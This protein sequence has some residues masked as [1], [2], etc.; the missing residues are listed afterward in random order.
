MY[1][2]PPYIN[3]ININITLIVHINIIVSMYTTSAHKPETPSVTRFFCIFASF[4]NLCIYK[5]FLKKVETM[6]I[7][8]SSNPCL[9]CQP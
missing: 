6:Q 4:M 9:V 3:S 1:P 8:L 5:Y 7:I 2:I